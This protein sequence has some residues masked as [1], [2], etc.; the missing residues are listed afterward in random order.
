MKNFLLILMTGFLAS[1][2]KYSDGTS[3]WADGVWI[4]FWLPFLASF[5]FLYFA[6][7]AHKSNSTIQ[8]PTGGN[9]PNLPGGGSWIEDNTG[10]VPLHKIGQFWFFVILQ[11][12][13][14]A[15]VVYQNSQV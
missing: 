14:W 13:S 3:V 1:C 15:I 6:W 2:S 5:A 12:A 9:N 11:V 7:K 8:H 4:I 10:N